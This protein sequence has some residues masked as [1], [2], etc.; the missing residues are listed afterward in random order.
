MK[1]QGRTVSVDSR[2]PSLSAGDVRAIRYKL[3][4]SQSEFA[5]MIGVTLPMLQSWEEGKRVPDGPALALL[6][7]TAKNPKIV[8]KALAH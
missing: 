4:Q 1:G 5:T 3:G 2:L 7:V 6:R 8:A